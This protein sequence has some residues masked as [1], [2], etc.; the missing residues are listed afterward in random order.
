MNNL[1]IKRIHIY[2]IKNL[3]IVAR[4]L[5]LCGRD[6]AKKYDLHH[7]DNHMIKSSIIVFLCVLRNQ[8]YLVFDGKKPISTFQIKKKRD[9]LFFEKLA[10]IPEAS[11]KGYGSYC[12]KMI[13][14]QAKKMGCHKICMEVYDQSKH[15]IEFYKHNGYSRVGKTETLK[16]TDLIME[17]I[18]KL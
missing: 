6:M 16:Y 7:W 4:I 17:K 14:N 5:N 15:A 9:A 12:M 13:E 3:L 1:R 8:I 2:E 11:G 18:V 10:V